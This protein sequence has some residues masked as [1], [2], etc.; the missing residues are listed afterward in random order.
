MPFDTGIVACVT[1]LNHCRA[2]IIPCHPAEI[3]WVYFEFLFFFVFFIEE[4]DGGL[5]IITFWPPS[6]QTF[7]ATSS[8]IARS[9]YKR[10]CAY[11]VCERKQ[12]LS[13]YIQFRVLHNWSVSPL[14][15]SLFLPSSFGPTTK[16]PLS[17]SPPALRHCH[18]YI[19]HLIPNPHHHIISLQGATIGSYIDSQLYSCIKLLPSTEY[20]TQRR[21]YQ[22]LQQF[23]LHAL[24]SSRILTNL[25]SSS[26]LQHIQLLQLALPGAVTPNNQ[27]ND[28][29]CPQHTLRPRP[30]SSLPFILL[31][32]FVR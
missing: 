4:N 32:A 20:Y 25:K 16:P 10:G 14:L 31:H 11:C 27:T 7:S 9:S 23:E 13:I 30:L 2:Q 29:G 21:A 12:D 3:N 26:E 6:K 22:H 15:H 5:S 24:S 19:T 28:T 1:W 8:C 17:H 18:H